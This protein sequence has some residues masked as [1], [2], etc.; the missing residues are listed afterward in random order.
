MSVTLSLAVIQRPGHWADKCKMVFCVF[1][2]EKKREIYLQNSPTSNQILS[3]LWSEAWNNWNRSPA[4]SSHFQS[5]MKVIKTRFSGHAMFVHWVTARERKKI[6]SCQHLLKLF[7]LQ[8]M[9]TVFLSAYHV[10]RFVCK[11]SLK[12][13]SNSPRGIINNNFKWGTA[14]FKTLF[15]VT[16]DDVLR[17]QIAL[18]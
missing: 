3:T 10:K 15:P 16:S 6:G 13:E 2:W 17:F 9:L 4:F 11:S 14:K 8:Y 18:K 12:P 1:N 5:L 7:T